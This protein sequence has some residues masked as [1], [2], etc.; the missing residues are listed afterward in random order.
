MNIWH[1][2]AATAH[3]SPELLHLWALLF[4]AGN[5]ATEEPWTNHARERFTRFVDDGSNAR[6][7]VI[8]VDSEI[9]ATAIGNLEL[10]VPNPQS[11]CTPRSTGAVHEV[12]ER[13]AVRCGCGCPRGVVAEGVAQR[14]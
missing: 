12:V 6:F 11:G 10:G 14:A 4:D 7:P 2:R 8:E 1:L 5:A 13:A 9:V 3:D